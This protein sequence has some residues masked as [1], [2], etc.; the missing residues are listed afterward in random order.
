LD[1]IA[2]S[3]G[4]FVGLM[5]VGSGN[6]YIDDESNDKYYDT[7]VNTESLLSGYLQSKKQQVVDFQKLLLKY[8]R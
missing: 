5:S 4:V 6:L 8:T 7:L 3:S 2:E 1:G